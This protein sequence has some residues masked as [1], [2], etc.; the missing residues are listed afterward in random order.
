MRRGIDKEIPRRCGLSTKF[1]NE[2]AR[3]VAIR[4]EETTNWA[5]KT[6][7]ELTSPQRFSA[8]GAV[9]MNLLVAQEEGGM[10]L[11]AGEWPEE[12]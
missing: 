11:T 12:E 10:D 8:R 7:D 4:E 9:K 5:A 1:A 2:N 3:S 6:A